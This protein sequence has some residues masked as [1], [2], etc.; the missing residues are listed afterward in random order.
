MEIFETHPAI[1]ALR[2]GEAVTDLLLVALERTLRR[3][4]GGSNIQLSESNIRKAFNL[5]MTSLLAFLRVLLEFEALPDYKD[6]VERNFEQFITQH[7]YNANQIRFLR[8]VQSVFLQK[9]RL[10]VTDLYD[11]P[12][13]RFGE[14]AVERWFT[15]DEV[16]ELIYFTEQFAA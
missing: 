5:K 14:D 10:E 7:Q 4:L 13:D 11:E 2:N 3:E 8:A 16:N 6:I 15:E 1:T 12:L 9:R